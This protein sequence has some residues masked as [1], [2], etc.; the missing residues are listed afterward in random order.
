M[1]QVESNRVDDMKDWMETRMKEK[2]E[3]LEK[4]EEKLEKLEAMEKS[5]RTRL[6]K[7]LALREELERK[8]LGIKRRYKDLYNNETTNLKR[9]GRS[10]GCTFR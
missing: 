7:R 3:E 9:I 2:E 1:G 10:G 8:E 6:K 5:E 4:R